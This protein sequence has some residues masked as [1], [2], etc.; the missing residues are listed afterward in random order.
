MTDHLKIV[1]FLGGSLIIYLL[2]WLSL[3]PSYLGF[4]LLL[5]AFIVFVN[6]NNLKKEIETKQECNK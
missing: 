2:V 6:F 5:I 4:V 1:Y 3:P